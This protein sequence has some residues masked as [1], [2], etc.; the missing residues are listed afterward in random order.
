MSSYSVFAGQQQNNYTVSNPTQRA[1]E[2]IYLERSIGY[3]IDVT[4][5]D[6]TDGT[7]EIRVHPKTI[8]KD[9]FDSRM[10]CEEIRCL[11][12]AGESCW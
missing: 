1:N 7:I 5:C 9:G 2:G 6:Y 4:K 10:R 8:V 11:V 3:E 12:E